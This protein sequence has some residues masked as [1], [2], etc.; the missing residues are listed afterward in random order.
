MTHSIV[1][2]FTHSEGKALRARHSWGSLLFGT[3]SELVNANRFRRRRLQAFMRLIDAV[4]AEQGHCRVL[5]VGGRMAHWQAHADLWTGKPVSITLINLDTEAA[6]HPFTCLV[7][8][9][10]ELDQFADNSFDIVYSNS[11]I[12]HVGQWSDQKKMARAVRRVAPRHYVQTP[13]YWF[14]IEPHFRFPFIHWLPEPW[15]VGLVKRKA[16]GF[17]ARA[18]DASQ[19]RDILEDAR[20]LDAPAMRSLFPCS[21]ILREKIGPFTKSLIAVK[22]ERETF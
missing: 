2:G 17:Y 3:S 16:L 22:S 18:K 7:G 12:E 1:S 8:D 11:V 19:A 13:N 20:L 10:R 9:A 21:T 5:D 6:V 15:R 4:I 14:P